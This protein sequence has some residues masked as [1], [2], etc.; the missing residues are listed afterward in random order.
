[1]TDSASRLLAISRRLAEIDE[2]LDKEF[3]EPSTDHL[4]LL[5]ERDALRGQAS[6]FRANRNA[7]RQTRELEAEL[8][9]LRKRRATL[10][11]THTGYV[12]G[13]G[14]GNASPS[15]GEWVILAARAREAGD[16]GRMD[17]R[18]AEIESE[19]A[20]RRATDHGP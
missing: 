20:S 15:P 19:L 3:K 18:I 2:A 11:R 8:T 12:T 1:M 16:L 7:S 9:E 17:A 4:A 13:K 5:R 14:G 10:I 6:E